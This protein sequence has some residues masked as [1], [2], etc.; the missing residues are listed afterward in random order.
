MNIYHTG[1]DDK[2]SD[3]SR[4]LTE[5]CLSRLAGDTNQDLFCIMVI[6][7]F[8]LSIINKRIFYTWP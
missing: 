3:G 4:A 2:N 8:I 7:A 6:S 5:C 1:P